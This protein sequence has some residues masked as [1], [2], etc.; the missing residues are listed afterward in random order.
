MFGKARRHPNSIG[1]KSK[2]GERKFGHE[3][4]PSSI[5]KSRTS[6]NTIRKS[7]KARKTREKKM[8]GGRSILRRRKG[9]DEKKN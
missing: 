9:N 6:A 3:R 2:I 7:Q 8:G 4:L 1:E 5:S